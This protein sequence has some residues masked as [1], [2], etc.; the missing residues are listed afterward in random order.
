MS[1]DWFDVDVV[2]AL[3]AATAQAVTGYLGWAAS[4]DRIKKGRKTLY[5]GV[6]V[7]ATICG[8]ISTVAAAHRAVNLVNELHAKMHVDDFRFQS[9]RGDIVDP[10][11]SLIGRQLA[12]VVTST[13]R[14]ALPVQHLRAACE[15]TI[16]PVLSPADE[17]RLFDQLSVDQKDRLEQ[18]NQ[19][20]VLQGDN[21]K[22][23]CLTKDRA[24][25]T[26]EQ[27]KQLTE[28]VN[29]KLSVLYVTL[30]M[31][32]TDKLGK[33]LT[34]ENCWHFYFGRVGSVPGFKTPLDYLNHNR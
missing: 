29:G 16:T 27:F 33:D 12:G 6:F 11:F 3:I 18:P 34:T 2:L 10:D 4:V 32:Y 26:E 31:R 25:L 5:R 9:P 30:L 21:Q 19:N 8:I 7:F 20:E 22:F 15:V 1:F 23:A 17:D 24:P 14:G 13:N 28:G